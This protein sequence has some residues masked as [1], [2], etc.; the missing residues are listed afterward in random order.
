MKNV[1]YYNAGAGSGK[2]YTLTHLLADK[3][4]DGKTPSQMILTTF[5]NKAADDLRQRSRE[6]LYEQKLNEAAALLD[7]AAI[8]TVHSLGQ[9]FVTKFWHLLGLSPKMNVMDEESTNFYINRSL[10]ELPTDEELSLFRKFRRTF[11]LKKPYPDNNKSYDDFWKDLLKGVIDRA[12]WYRVSDF[13]KSA[14]KSVERLRKIFTPNHVFVKTKADYIWLIE[15]LKEV[16]AGDLRKTA[17]GRQNKL[18]SLEKKKVWDFQDFLQMADCISAAP[19]TKLDPRLPNKQ[20]IITELLNIWHSHQAFDLMEKTVRT[21]FAIAARWMSQY[22]KYKDDHRILD[23]NDMER[24]FITL[25]KKSEIAQEISGRYRV[26]MVDEFQDSSPVQVDIFNRLSDL[27]EETY[28]CGDSKQAIYAFRGADTD[29]TEAI[30]GMVEREFK[31][32]KLDT[33]YRSEPD[34]VN[35]CNSVFTRAFSNKLSPEKV[36]LNSHREKESEGPSLMHWVS[37]ESGNEKALQSLVEKVQDFALYYD[38]P[39]R[40]IAILARTNIDLNILCEEFR[41]VDIPV[42][43][44]TG[45]LENLRE[46]ELMLS[47]LSLTVQP[48][49]TL[50]RAKVAWLTEDGYDLSALIDSRISNLNIKELEDKDWLA[51]IPLIK[52]VMERRREWEAQGVSTLVETIMTELNLRA[53]LKSWSGNWHQR[54]DN[55][56]LLMGHAQKYEQYCRTMAFAATINGFISWIRT[57]EA[58]GLGDSEGIV[59]ST[60]HGAKGLE[61]NNVILVSLGKDVKDEGNMIGREIFGIHE[62]RVEAPS[63]ENFFPEVWLSL[64]PNVFGNSVPSDIKAL[65]I[66]DEEY[67]LIESKAVEESKR[68]LYVGMTRAR[69][70]LITFAAKKK[71]KTHQPMATFTNIGIEIPELNQEECLCDIFGSGIDVHVNPLWE[72]E[73]EDLVTEPIEI[74]KDLPP[75]IGEFIEY[76]SRYISPSTAKGEVGVTVELAG[77]SHKRIP[78]HGK[79]EMDEVGNCIHNAYA[80][81]KGEARHDLEV[82]ER[83]A[84]GFGFDKVLSDK[85]AIVD[86]YT[87]LANWLN[88]KY[89]AAEVV[90][91]ELPFMHEVG[92]QVVRGSMDLVWETPDGCVLVDFKTFPGGAS[93]VM[94]PEHDHYAGKYGMQFLC[95]EEAIKASGRKVIASYVYYPV[96]G[97]LVSLNVKSK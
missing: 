39:Y 28:L 10:A 31:M 14:E 50:A 32:E 82:V 83:I 63:R 57:Q 27:V 73:E 4:K 5:T 79:P 78:V 90:H 87:W 3:I 22:E 62:M 36:R 56:Y 53:I 35:L 9:Q 86:A 46:I 81:F 47:L 58:A 92:N 88:E 26:L 65:M 45:K 70:R 23:F 76:D 95:Y 96:A 51:D 52:K 89:G 34:I 41:K 44:K 18:F 2:T 55:L 68:L 6:V 13:N 42:F 25:L 17:V 75:I 16:D 93:S 94:S 30:A 54:E 91:H 69:Q 84:R 38:I 67:V 71:N 85:Q 80:A 74:L 12:T 61:W 72:F 77:Q 59:L 29:L 33:S 40:D 15:M 20:D 8:G 48:N 43:Y 1:I 66:N 64:M 19:N 37:S 49:N 60:L 24:H 11:D 21:I 97:L 7:Q